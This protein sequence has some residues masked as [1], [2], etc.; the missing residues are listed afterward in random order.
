M[1]II[2]KSFNFWVKLIDEITCQKKL[3]KMNEVKTENN[4]SASVNF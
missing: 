2:G 4:P 1:I 3:Q